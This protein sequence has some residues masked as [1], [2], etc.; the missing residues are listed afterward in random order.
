MGATKKPP[1]RL[2]KASQGEMAY[3]KGCLPAGVIRRFTRQFEANSIALTLLLLFLETAAEVN[4]VNG[5]PIP[6][7]SAAVEGGRFISNS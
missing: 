2:P 5:G 1:G 4:P 3:R 6:I 7:F